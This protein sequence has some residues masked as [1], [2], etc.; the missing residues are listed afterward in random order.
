VNL[1]VELLMRVMRPPIQGGGQVSWPTWRSDLGFDFPADYKDF[2]E[3]YGGGTID[4]TVSITPLTDDGGQWRDEN[5]PGD[6]E[7]LHDPLTGEDLELP[8]HWGVGGLVSWGAG[9]QSNVTG[10]RMTWI[11]TNGL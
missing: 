4:Q 10:M 5:Q 11:L 7:F 9:D 6:Y 8:L 2:M 1:S 3:I